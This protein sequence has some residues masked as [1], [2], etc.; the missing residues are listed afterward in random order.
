MNVSQVIAAKSARNRAAH[1]KRI[2][3]ANYAVV[4]PNP[5]IPVEKP[6][7]TINEKK[8]RLKAPTKANPRCPTEHQEQCAV[9]A[10]ADTHP[11]ACMIF[12]IPNGSHK[13]PAMAAKFQREGLRKGYPDLGLDVARKG[14]HGLRIELKRVKGSKTSEEQEDWRDF[15][16]SQDYAA[17]ICKGAD[18]AIR[19]IKDYLGE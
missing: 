2:G 19:V 7:K 16:L 10:W 11:L 17:H 8:R 12:A 3:E 5:A 18:E 9:I 13:S 4:G 1:V 6:A 14:F 15:L